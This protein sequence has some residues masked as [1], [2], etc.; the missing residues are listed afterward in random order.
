MSTYGRPARR[1]RARAARRRRRRRPGSA[2]VGRRAS[3]AAPNST[4]PPR[5]WRTSVTRGWTGAMGVRPGTKASHSSS[6]KPSASAASIPRVKRATPRPASRARASTPTFIVQTGRYRLARLCRRDHGSPW[7]TTSSWTCAG[8][9]ASSSPLCDLFPQADLFTAVYD[10]QGTEGRFAHRTVHTS[11]LQR[12]RPNA[13]TFRALLPLYPA[14][15]ESLDLRGYDLV[16]LELE[17]VGARRHPRRG[18]RPRLLLPQPVPLRVERAPGDAGRARP[19]GAR[20]ARGGVPALAPVGLD[21]RPARRRLR[22][23]LADDQA[24]RRALL[25]PR[26]DRAAPAGRRRALHARPSRARPTSCS[27]S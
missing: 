19:A 21:R 25:R 14:A 8:Q 10:E 24:A 27:P 18:R 26:R 12:L 9:S 1:A 2:S 7:C 4:R 3:A 17:R 15:M 6:P 22:R 11:Y 23:Q 13:R 5:R 16:H 20:G